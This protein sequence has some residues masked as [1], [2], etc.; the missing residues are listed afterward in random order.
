MLARIVA[1]ATYGMAG[2][3]YYD[4]TYVYMGGAVTPKMRIGTKQKF[5]TKKVIKDCLRFPAQ[6]FSLVFEAAPNYPAGPRK[7]PARER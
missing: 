2:F 1:E 3:A 6:I 7:T 4:T 5:A